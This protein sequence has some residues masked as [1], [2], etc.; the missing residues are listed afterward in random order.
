[1]VGS[2]SS[3]WSA[4]VNMHMCVFVFLNIA[5]RQLLPWTE[6]DRCRGINLDLIHRS[7]DYNS[8]IKPLESLLPSSNV[9]VSH[10]W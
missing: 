6:L 1:M 5:A 7:L 3:P 8:I 4:I 2:G 10:H 9:V